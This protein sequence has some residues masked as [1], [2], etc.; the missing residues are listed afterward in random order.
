M[1]QGSTFL[2]AGFGT[3]I[4]KAWLDLALPIPADVRA[5][6]SWL[7]RLALSLGVRELHDQ[8]LQCYRRHGNN[9]AD[10]LA[11]NPVWMAELA[12]S[13]AHSLSNATKGWWSELERIEATQLRLM[14]RTV[15][16]RN[17][18]LTDWQV[19]AMSLLVRHAA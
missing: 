6:D 16:L 14:D 1:A 8:P 4:L 15:A 12:A 7:H 9:S 2:V 5:H 13:C 11:R 17:L 3:A 18:G 10:G 19:A